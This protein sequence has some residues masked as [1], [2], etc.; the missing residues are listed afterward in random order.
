MMKNKKIWGTIFLF[1]IFYFLFSFSS[2]A[3]AATLYAGSATETVYE[4]QSFVIEWYMD[5]EGVN[6]NSLS[7]K[8]NFTKET[9][10]VVEASPGDSLINLWVTAPKYSNEQGTI[11]L[12][13]G[14]PSGFVSANAPIFR[15]IFKA[16]SQGRG[17]IIMED[18]SMVVGGGTLA[19]Q[20]LS[21]KFHILDF[22]IL[23]QDFQAVGI[24]STSHPYSDKWYKE[25]RVVIN[26]ALKEQGE[27]SYSF[28]SNLDIFPD[29][30]KDEYAGEI[31]YENL[32]DGIYYFKLSSK[33][34]AGVWQDA[35]VFRVQIDATPPEEFTPIVSKTPEA[36][37]GKPFL[38]FV[39]IDKTSGISHYQI[40]IGNLGKWKNASSPLE[41]PFLYFGDRIF[42]K[43]V[44]FA[45]N[46]RVSVVTSPKNRLWMFAIGLGL[47]AGI[48]G[49]LYGIYRRSRRHKN[50][51]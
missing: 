38:S 3:K 30:V 37:G 16:K 28:S 48:I 18:N 46:S 31:V 45:G 42:V 14:V 5:T 7:L 50:A 41:L 26:F 6:A 23:P 9:L 49:F 33:I 4:G 1:S 47:S 19:G 29:D 25:N 51:P 21:L 39:S 34:A 40:K 12:V 2:S 24:T 43:A 13:G 11:E 10:E 15:T 27:Y 32:P 17:K 20:P 35:G 8:L 22:P 36:F 44:D